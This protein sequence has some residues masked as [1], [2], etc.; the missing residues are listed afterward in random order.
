MKRVNYYATEKMMISKN[1]KEE[2]VLLIE[3]ENYR[4]SSK[5]AEIITKETGKPVYSM[6]R[7][8]SMDLTAYGKVAIARRAYTWAVLY[9]FFEKD[10]WTVCTSRDIEIGKTI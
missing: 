7:A 4:E 2:F 1:S 10:S 6:R 5:I 9:S 8:E 3:A